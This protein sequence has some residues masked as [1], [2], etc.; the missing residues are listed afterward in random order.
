MHATLTAAV[1]AVVVAAALAMPPPRLPKESAP[2]A[3]QITD[4][5]FSIPEDVQRYAVS[6]LNAH[7]PNPTLPF[8]GPQKDDWYHSSRWK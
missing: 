4:R 3:F 6:I 2:P 8:T 1:L 5:G 7:R